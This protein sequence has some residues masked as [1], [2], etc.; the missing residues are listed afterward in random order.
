MS[1]S[2]RYVGALTTPIYEFL[3]CSSITAHTQTFAEFGELPVELQQTI[4]DWLPLSDLC[5]LRLVSRSTHQ[6][7][8]NA[9]QWQVEAR[10]A[11]LHRQADRG[12]EGDQETW[13]Q[14]YMRAAGEHRFRRLQS[15]SPMTP[16][17]ATRFH[18]LIPEQVELDLL[19]D[20][21]IEL[22]ERRCAIDDEHIIGARPY[23]PPRKGCHLQ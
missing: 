10:A 20:D 4:V 6:L 16:L 11:G 17:L 1:L 22:C 15:Q 13:R 2:W 3:L 8:E 18:K 19:L 14:A 7:A 9:R 5:A 23:T 21:R 12:A